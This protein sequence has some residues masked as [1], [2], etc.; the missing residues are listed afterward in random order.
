MPRL[1]EFERHRA[2]GMLETG[3]G[4]NEVTRRFGVHQNTI[5]NLWRR[6][7]QQGN[8]RSPACDVTSTGQSYSGNASSESISVGNLD[9]QNH[10]WLESNQCQDSSQPF[11]G[12]QHEAETP[13]N[14]SYSAATS[15]KCA[16]SME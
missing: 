4:H 12:A 5:Q 8:T 11:T 7:Q 14:T 16:S 10:P 13:I 6:Y 2:V 3:M 15:P 9:S 1:S